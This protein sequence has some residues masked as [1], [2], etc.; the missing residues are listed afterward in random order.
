MDAPHP[1]KNPIML[2]AKNYELVIGAFRTEFTIRKDT[3]PISSSTLIINEKINY[4]RFLC[5]PVDFAEKKSFFRLI[6]EKT[7]CAARQIRILARK[8]PLEALTHKGCRGYCFN[9]PV[10]EGD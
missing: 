2:L 7:A 8:H 5:A 1:K 3:R 10:I 6:Q 4:F 9:C